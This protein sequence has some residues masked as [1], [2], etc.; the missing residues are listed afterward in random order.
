MRARVKSDTTVR[1]I[2][3]EVDGAPDLEIVKEY[4]KKVQVLA[5]NQVVIKTL[6]DK[7]VSARVSGHLRRKDGTIG[8]TTGSREWNAGF[9]NRIENAPDFVRQ[10]FEEAPDGIVEWT[11]GAQA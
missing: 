6:D 10:I 3:V 5:V 1:T 9:G 8:E 7:R 4:L 11:W 2:V